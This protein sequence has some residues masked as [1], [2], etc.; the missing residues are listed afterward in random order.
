MLLDLET[1]SP[2]RTALENTEEDFDLIQ[3]TG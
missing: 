2:E 1:G 3:P